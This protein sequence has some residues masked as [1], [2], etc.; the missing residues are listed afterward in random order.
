[1]DV[2]E[3]PSLVDFEQV[4]LVLRLDL[5]P[6]RRELAVKWEQRHVGELGTQH[7]RDEAQVYLI[8]TNL[9]FLHHPSSG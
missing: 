4:G 9:R 3:E 8:A 5:V 2:G 6:P 1:M 7:D